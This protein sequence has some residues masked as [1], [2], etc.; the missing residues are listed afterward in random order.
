MQI[1][2]ILQQVVSTDLISLQNNGEH[3]DEPIT[4]GCKR[5]KL[6]V[7]SFFC[8]NDGYTSNP[9]HI[10]KNIKM[11][12]QSSSCIMNRSQQG[13]IFIIW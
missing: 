1:Y 13:F 4:G 11:S 6:V 7:F 12:H 10:K 5:V 2:K 9:E 8:S 3:F